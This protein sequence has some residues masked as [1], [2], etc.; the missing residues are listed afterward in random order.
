MTATF[1]SGRGHAV[2]IGESVAVL[3]FGASWFLKGSEIFNML[4]EEHG[5]RPWLR[6]GVRK[7]PLKVESHSSV[8][9]GEPPEAVETL[10]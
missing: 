3:V 7:G 1:G 2:L 8:V 5:K 4:R 10:T 6:V 9:S